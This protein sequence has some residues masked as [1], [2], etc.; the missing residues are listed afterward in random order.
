M[1]APLL[2]SLCWIPHVLPGILLSLGVLW[3][4]LATPL[5]FFLYGTVWGIAFALILADSPVTTQAFKAGLLQL[6]ADLEESARVSG[7]SWTLHLPAHSL[8]AVGAHRGGGR[9]DEFRQRL[10]QH[11]HSRATLQPRVAAAGDLAA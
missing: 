5:R 3:L 9:P 8:A 7:A 6:G 10:D 1:T 4:F 2:E 11:Q